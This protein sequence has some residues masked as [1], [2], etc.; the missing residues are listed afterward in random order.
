MVDDEENTRPLTKPP[1]ELPSI[2][3]R[4]SSR[5]GRKND[6]DRVVE[7]DARGGLRANLEVAVVPLLEVTKAADEVREPY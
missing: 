7:V 4:L 5:L 1:V 2:R 6:A 3:G